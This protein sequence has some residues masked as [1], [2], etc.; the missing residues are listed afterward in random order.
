MRHDEEDGL[1]VNE[2]TLRSIDNAAAWIGQEIA[3]S[4]AWTYRLDDAERADA[5]RLAG[6]A[7]PHDINMDAAR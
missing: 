4:D 5:L 2:N 6:E 7:R 3:K 1:P